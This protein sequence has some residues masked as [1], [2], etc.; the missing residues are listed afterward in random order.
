MKKVTF[1]FDTEFDTNLLHWRDSLNPIGDKFRRAADQIRNKA[2]AVAGSEAN[3]SLTTQMAL[4]GSRYKP[5]TREGYKRAKAMAYSLRRYAELVY[6][7]EV[8]GVD[9]NYAVVGAGHA[10]G[11][12]IEYG[13]ADRVIKI[14]TVPLQ[15]PALGILRRSI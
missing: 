11:D 10:A 8:H 2:K 15:Y 12:V 7:A 9:S 5:E 3:T 14:G 6:A 13:G 1:V 4:A